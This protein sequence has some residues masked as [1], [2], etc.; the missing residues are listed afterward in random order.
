MVGETR[1]RC[2]VD[3]EQ[4]GRQISHLQLPHSS[5]TS[6]YGWIGI[7]IS[8]IRNGRGPTLYLEA[9]NHG[10]EYEG[11]I[12]LAQ[13]DPGARAGADQG[14]RDHPAGGQPAGGDGRHAG[15]ADRRRQPQPRAS[16]AI[17]TAARP[18]RSP[19]IIDSVLLP[20][21]DRLPRSPFRRQVAASTSRSPR[22]AALRRPAGR[23][24]ARGAEGVR[25]AD[26]LS[27]RARGARTGRCSRPPT[28]RAWSGSGPS[29]AAP[30]P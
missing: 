2:F 11:Q 16:P 9:G 22:S 27:G 20:M 8:V 19:T 5:N 10:D 6:A 15:V 4:D 18:Q 23:G 24:Q 3:F 21:C 14:P 1:I 12:A 17:P 29:S 28:G 30:A 26:R 7:P 25:G 13:P